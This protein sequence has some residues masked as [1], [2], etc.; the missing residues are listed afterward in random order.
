MLPIITLHIDDRRATAALD[1]LG[2]IQ[3]G[4]PQLMRQIA[5]IMHTEVED[6]F[7]AQGRP[8]WMPLKPSS[9]GSKYRREVTT[10]RGN[11]RRDNIERFR[12]AVRQN[13]ILQASGSLASSV[14]MFSSATQAIVG[15][16]K[17]YAAIHQFG[18][19]TKAHII[20]ARRKRALAFG[21]ILRRQVNHPGSVIPA[22]PYLVLGPDGGTR[23]ESATAR[24]LR[25]LTEPR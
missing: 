11:V 5:G 8:R 2:N 1:R 22:R 6:N 14:V 4:A 3:S 15:S 16:N 7:D 21:G 9:L 19:K 20:R 24:Y 10:R 25:T 17:V 12:N 18:G 23:I 13:K